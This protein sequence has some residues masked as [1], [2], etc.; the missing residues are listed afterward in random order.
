MERFWNKVDK[1]GPGGCWLWTASL[2][3]RGYGQFALDRI[4]GK[5][6]NVRAHRFSYEQIVGPVPQGFEL[7]HLCRV[8][9]CVRPDHLD[10][11]PHIVNVHR[12]AGTG[13]ALWDGSPPAGALA[14]AAKTHCPQGHPYSIENTYLSN[15]GRF[16]KC[17][18]CVL[19]RMRVVKAPKT[20]CRNGHTWTDENRQRRP[21]GY[22]ACRLCANEAARR[23]RAKTAH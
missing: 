6:R 5:K 19:D 20:H 17:R 22:T 4:E 12:G 23:H 9:H 13:A 3:G 2:D 10:A 7:D 14:N 21:N 15:G 11:V 18:T 16:R 8:R 1:N